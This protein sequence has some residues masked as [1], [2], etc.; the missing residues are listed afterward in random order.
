M[1]PAAPGNLLFTNIHLVYGRVPAARG[2][3]DGTPCQLPRSKKRKPKSGTLPPVP[4]VPSVLKAFGQRDFAL[5]IAQCRQILDRDPR[6]IDALNLLGG[7]Y[8]EQG[9]ASAAIDVLT[10]A[11]TLKPGD[12]ALEANL[13]L[14]LATAKRFDAAEEHLIRAVA[15]VPDDV[16]TL[17]NLA[18]VQFERE[19]FS[20]ATATFA[21]AL[22]LAPNHIGILTDAI[23]AAVLAGDTAV[24]QQYARRAIAL[25]VRDAAAQHQL[26][27]VL[28]EHRLYAES[29]AVADAALAHDSTDAS[30]HIAKG[31]VLSR[32]ERH[33]DALASFDAALRHDPDNAD[34]TLWRSF[35]NL[36]L[37]RFYDGWA[38]YRARQTQRAAAAP[39][40]LAACG[41]GYHNTPL[42]DDL[43]GATIL[44]DRDQGLGDE[45]FFLRFAPVLRARGATVTYRS[46][47]RIGPLLRRA[48]VVDRVVADAGARDGY[49][50][51]VSVCD[52]P[53]LVGAGAADSVPPSIEIPPLPDQT[54]K[55][56]ARLAAF[57]DG[58]YVGV[59]WR[60]GTVG[61]NRFLHKEVPAEQ[62]AGAIAKSAL[63]TTG[64]VVVTQRNPAEGEVAAFAEAL[65]RP[66]LD[67]S[68][69]NSDLEAMLALSA[70]LDVYVGVSNT[71]LYLRDATRRPSHV[72]VPFP[73]E[74]RW[75]VA[76][77]DS[78]WFPGAIVY[79]QGPDASWEAAMTELARTLDTTANPLQMAV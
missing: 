54:A 36:S 32:L 50:Y 1:L 62:L 11:V 71:N 39:N 57:G 59:T 8:I 13:G 16:D 33:D 43:S 31:G 12:A 19:L 45:L 20:K 40:S 63:G 49:D 6:N 5:A 79:R 10:R 7:A 25:D 60:A 52:L 21:S 58:P 47:V 34:A 24:A 48:G 74:F 22:A 28:H 69:L 26:I 35:L 23:R 64:T 73:P 41:E 27:R 53:W 70:L 46:D 18:R 38:G 44:V 78:P 61:N 2:T 72:M 77:R 76:G 42:P 68:G 56:A 51:L 14:A 37:G 30:L 67:L 15:Q 9:D 75:L 66:V 65:G 3:P 29:L 17:A 55:L 4:S